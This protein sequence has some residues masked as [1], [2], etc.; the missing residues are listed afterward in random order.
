LPSEHFLR[1]AIAANLAASS[2]ND[3]TC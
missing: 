1:A 3:E 2:Q